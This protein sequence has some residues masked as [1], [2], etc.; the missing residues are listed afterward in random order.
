MTKPWY[1]AYPKGVAQTIDP[2]SYKSIIQLFDESMQKFPHKQAYMNMG[3][4]L[5]FSELNDLSRDFA[6]YLQNEVGLKKGDRI[7]IQMPNLIQYPIVLFA[8][9]RAGLIV[10]N[11]NPLYTAREM[12]F[13]FKDSGAKAI[14]I[15]ANFAYNLEEVIADTDIQSVVVT[16]IGDMLGFPKRLLINA[17]V[18]HVKKMVPKYNLPKAVSFLDALDIGSE[19]KFTAA[20]T[21]GDDIAFLQYTGGTTGVPK[22]AMLTHFNLYSN[23]IQSYMWGRELTQSGDERYLMVIPYF[24]IYGQTVGMLLG[25]W[26]GAMQIPVPKFDPDALIQAIK[27]YKPTFFPGVPTLYISMLNHPEIKTCGLEYVR[28]F[29]S[30]SAPLPVEVIEQFE[31]LSGAMLYEGYGL[32]EASPTTHSTPTLARR[33][34]GSIG[35]TYPATDAKIVDLE[36]GTLEVPLGQEGELCIRGPQVMKGYWNRPDET[37][38]ALRDGWLY[39]GD[40]ARMDEDGYFYIVQRKK[41][42]II[43]SGFNVYPN[44]VEDVLFTHPAVLEAAVIGVPDQYRG[45]SVKAFVVLKPGVS[46][47]V[48]E[49]LEFCKTNLAKYKVP[50][51]IQITPSLPKSAVGKVLRR[52]LREMENAK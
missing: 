33:K 49:L 28:R 20:D 26:N 17:V 39:T 40:V 30:G 38:I 50:S 31:Q 5:S 9:I 37:A 6:A 11:T 46:A 43:V 52:E 1:K 23:V 2:N 27:A 14:V 10:V 8:A 4:T 15:L 41:D 36:T 47:T 24:H 19:K 12:K 16:E 18:K 48:E 29:N 44:E 42:M 32:T 45:E 21:T 13:Q 35:L 22:G 34:P 25:T 3:T 7:A 51:V